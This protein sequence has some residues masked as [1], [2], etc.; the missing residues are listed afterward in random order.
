[1][2]SHARRTG[3]RTLK[4]RGV[5]DPLRRQEI[6]SRDKRAGE[7]GIGND[8]FELSI[9]IPSSDR[10]CGIRVSDTGHG[11]GDR[12]P[13]CD[14]CLLVDQRRSFVEPGVLHCRIRFR[15]ANRAAAWRMRLWVRRVLLGIA[16]VIGV[17]IGIGA[18]IYLAEFG[19]G[20]KLANCYSLHSRCAE[21]GSVDCDGPGGIFADCCSDGTF[22]GILRRSGTGNHD[23]SHGS[24]DH[25]KRCC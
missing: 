3:Q 7:K 24:A 17:P 15:K 10:S 4:R 13:H 23:D 21:R 2:G 1:M 11:A 22:F 18:G 5:G 12:S 20:T 14:F 16:S 6:D 9:R 25:R 8:D 19:R